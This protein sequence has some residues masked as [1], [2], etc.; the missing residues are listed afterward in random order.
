M[1]FEASGE[2]NYNQAWEITGIVIS[3][4]TDNI[5]DIEHIQDIVE[6]TLMNMSFRKTAKL[7]I[8]YRA[9]RQENRNINFINFLI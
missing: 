3:K 6:E 8:L 5:I 7:Y 9:K 4:L 1:S 2:G